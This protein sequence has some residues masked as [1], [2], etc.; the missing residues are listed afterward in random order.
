MF[1]A[2]LLLVS[3]LLVTG[4]AQAAHKAVDKAGDN[5]GDSA[6]PGS[7]KSACMDGPIAQFGR[8]IGD[9]KI[10]DEQL[11]QDGSGW[12]PGDGARWIFECIGDGVGVQDYW[13]PN[14]GG[15]G[16]N[17]RVYNPDTGRWEIVWTATPINGLTHISAQQNDQGDIVMSVENPK[18]DPP[19]RITFFPPDEGGWNWVMEMSFD[20][21]KTWAPVY[22][23]K[24]TPW[25][26]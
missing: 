12:G 22:R 16:T 3:C 6:V 24:A 18:P 5:V 9:W 21:G 20:E 13:L 14:K 1:D 11:A 26:G 19:R 17:L 8:Y 2:R 4:I 23:I 15:F 10:E 25:A 7:P